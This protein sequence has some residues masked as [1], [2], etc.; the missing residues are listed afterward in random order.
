ML[1]REYYPSVT[2]IIC[3]FKV[4]VIPDPDHHFLAT[5]PSK[6]V[7]I[8]QIFSINV[9]PNDCLQRFMKCEDAPMDQNIVSSR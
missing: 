2:T 7:I 6:F 9:F 8:F 3:K 1:I 4:G 5:L